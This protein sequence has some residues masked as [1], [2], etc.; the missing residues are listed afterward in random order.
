MRRAL[1]AVAGRLAIVVG[2]AL[3][4]AGMVPPAPDAPEPTYHRPST[5][6]EERQWETRQLSDLIDAIREHEQQ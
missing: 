5:P 6:A 2:F 4:V 1:A 3:I